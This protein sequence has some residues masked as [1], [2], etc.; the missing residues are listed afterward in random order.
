MVD[1]SLSAKIS[2]A[3]LIIVLTVISAIMVIP[4]LH[5]VASSFS[6]QESLIQSRF[7]LFPTD[8]SLD[9]YTYIF[10][11]NTF[12]DGMKVSIFITVFGTVLKMIVTLMLAYA[13]AHKSMPGRKI[14]NYAVLVTLVFN[15][16]MIPNFMAITG[17]GLKNS[18]W[19]LILPGLIDPFNLIV[20]RGFIQ[21]IPEEIEES[22]KL[23]GANEARILFSIIVP[24]SMA[25]IAT[26]SLF[27]AVVIWNSYFDAILYI[28]DSKK[29]PVQVL[30][31]QIVLMSG[32][33]GDSSALG[34]DFYVPPRTVRMAVITAATAPILFVYPFVQKHFAK[35]VMLGSVKG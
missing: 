15:A 1:K 20:I 34:T 23:D 17:Y 14:M 19:A 5:V 8:F 21:A 3:V 9:A 18:L 10:S 30:L 27:Y 16:G 22:A 2:Q 11:T 25:A 4:I 24:L 13:L 31:R 35:G 12:F 32:G 33:L 28:S 7:L 26:F 29:F 6:T